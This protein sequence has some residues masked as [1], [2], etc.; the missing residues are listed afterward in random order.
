ME[1]IQILDSG[2]RP[3]GLVEWVPAVPG[4]L[5]AWHRD[6]RGTSHNHEHHLRLAH[7]YRVRTQREGGREAWL[8]V[9]VEFDEQ[10]SV[11]AVRGAILAWINRHEVLRTHVTLTGDRTDR[12]TTDPGT[13]HLRMSRIGWYNDPTLLIEQIAGSFDRAT[14][15]THWPAYRFATV[16]RAH[17]FSLLFAADHSLVDGY[18]LLN[19]QAELRELYRAAVERRVPELPPTGSY[20]DFSSVER[21]AADAADHRHTAVAVWTEFLSGGELPGFGLLPDPG[22]GAAA[23]GAHAQPSHTTVLLDDA[24]TRALTRRCTDLGGSLIGGILAAAAMVYRRESGADRF[25]TVMPRHTRNHVEFHGALGWFV[26]LAPVTV[27][28]S[29]DPDFP[30]ALDRVM[31][32]LD[33][34]REGSALPLLRLAQILDFDPEPKFV[35][36]FMDTRSVPGAESADAGAARALRSHAYS[37][38]EVYVWINRTPNGLRMHSRFPADA[39]DRPASAILQGFLDD[40]GGLLA[41][42]AEGE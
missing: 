32:S 3:G 28:V 42:I 34:A 9:A 13:V 4:G 11:P 23:D 25:T 14:A 36:S 12:Y 24:A 35:V 37:D 26:G 6:P 18:S 38:D 22:D 15:P 39:P 30:T 10:I 17:S 41:R 5:G 7:D 1:F 21:E 33:R 27:D 40:L 16:A 19:A 29:D 20:V 31:V 2:I 8:G